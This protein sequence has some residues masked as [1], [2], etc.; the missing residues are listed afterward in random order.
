MFR[1]RE[2]KIQDKKAVARLWHKYDLYE[3]SLDKRIT[4]DSEKSYIKLFQEIL[5]NKSNNVVIAEYDS[6]IVGIIDYIAYKK[7]KLRIGSLGN[8]FVLDEYRGKGI[9]SKLADYA[10][11]KLKRYRCKFIRSGVRVNNKR[12][13]KFW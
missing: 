1:I 7:G 13:Q 9:G 12:A 3:H 4:V 11:N 2:A 10:V 5:E 8:A 6:K